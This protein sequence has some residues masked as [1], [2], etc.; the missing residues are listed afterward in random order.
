MVMGP[1]SLLGCVMIGVAVLWAVRLCYGSGQSTSDD[2]IRLLLT[3][4]G[5]TLIHLGVLSAVV[6]LFFIRPDADRDVLTWLSRMTICSLLSV[7]LVIAVFG[8]AVA[9]FRSLEST[10]LMWLLTAAGE[11]AIPLSHLVRSYALERTDEVGLRAARLAD[12]LE[13]GVNLP[14]A[15]EK[16][17][18]RLPIEGDLAA[19]YGTE[20]GDLSSAIKGLCGGTEEV[21]GLVRA[22]IEKTCYLGIVT[23]VAVIQLAFLDLTI[24]PIFSRMYEEFQLELPPLTARVIQIGE[25]LNVIGPVLVFFGVVF[26]IGL[27]V[28]GSLYYLGW[29]PRDFF[30]LGRMTRRYDGALIMRALSVAIKQQKPIGRSIWTLSRLFPRRSVRQKLRQAGTRINNGEDWSQSLCRHK[31]IR[32]SDAAV[33]QAAQRVGNLE[34]ALAEMAEGSL[35]RLSYRLLLWL[36]VVFPVLILLLG[37][38]IGV[39]VTALFMPVIDLVGGL[40]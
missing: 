25:Q 2:L 36:N 32:R 33:F 7:P 28:F 29:L 20:T 12:L 34:W 39:S 11:R 19:R 21:D 13:E 5:W 40:S 22:A 4:G 27:A 6:Q 8:M 14:D 38:I 31:L 9:R 37:I 23:W 35:R 30:L 24:L 16:S 18:M 1:I 15:L 17:R 3:I 26:T 10:S